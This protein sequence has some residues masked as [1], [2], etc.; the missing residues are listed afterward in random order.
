MFLTILRRI[1]DLGGTTINPILLRHTMV[2]NNI[3]NLT[4]IKD[5]RCLSRRF[6]CKPSASSTPDSAG[7]RPDPRHYLAINGTNDKDNS[8]VDEIHDFIKTNVQRTTDKKG[9]QV[10]FTDQLPLQATVNPGNQGTLSS[11]THSINHVHV[12]EK[13]VETTLAIS[14]LRNGKALPDPYKDHPI[15]QG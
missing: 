6:N 15:H 5:S 2:S 7:I 9:K 3:N 10:T 12:G 11:Q 8:H 1:T 14:S 13:A 4:L